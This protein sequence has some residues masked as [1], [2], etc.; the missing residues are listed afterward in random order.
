M[1]LNNETG[2]IQDLAGIAWIDEDEQADVLVHSDAVRAFSSAETSMS[3]S[4]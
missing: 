3:T 2:V 1:Y 4:V